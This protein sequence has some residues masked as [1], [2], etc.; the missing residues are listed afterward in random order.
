MAALQVRIGLVEQSHAQVRARQP[1]GHII[2]LGAKAAQALPC[3]VMVRMLG[4]P[5]V[6]LCMQTLLLAAGFEPQLPGN[7]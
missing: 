3:Q 1:A 7:R 2:K 4:A 6:D 5:L